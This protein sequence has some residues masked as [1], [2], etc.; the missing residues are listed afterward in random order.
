M[1]ENQSEMEFDGQIKIQLWEK[2]KCLLLKVKQWINSGEVLNR[3]ELESIR[4]ALVYLQR[5]CPA[6]TP[7]VKGFHLTIDS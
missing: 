6:I 4:G 2:M 5:T 7:Y 3:K 1:M